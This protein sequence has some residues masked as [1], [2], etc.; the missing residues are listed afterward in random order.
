MTV[1]VPDDASLPL[2]T[3]DL[4]EFTAGSTGVEGP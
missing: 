2:R 1:F 3:I 4:C